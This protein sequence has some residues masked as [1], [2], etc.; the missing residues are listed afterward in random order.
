MA[1]MGQ[2]PSVALPCLNV[3]FGSKADIQIRPAGGRFGPASR[4][5]LTIRWH[6]A[7]DTITPKQIW[8]M[9]SKIPDIFA[10][11]GTVMPVWQITRIDPGYIY[12]VK[13]GGHYKIGKTKKSEQRIKAAKTWLPDMKLIGV[14]PFWG[15]SHHE[16]LLHTGFAAYWYQGEWFNFKGGNLRPKRT[17]ATRPQDSEQQR[18]L[19]YPTST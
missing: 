1:G 16:R 12:I 5:C 7:A 10:R 11:A 4:H 15:V 19:G 9:A 14:K 3:C 18:P 6:Y 2:L 13:N 8:Q 17:Q